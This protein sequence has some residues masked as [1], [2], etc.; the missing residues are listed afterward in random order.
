MKADESRIADVFVADCKKM[1]GR[2]LVCVVLFGSVARGTATKRSDM[3]FLV[4]AR[5]LPD[6][7]MERH[8][9]FHGLRVKYLLDRGVRPSVIALTPGDM[10]TDPVNPLF[11]G[12]LTGYNVLYERDGFFSKFLASLKPVV[13]KNRP[14]YSEGGAAGKRWKIA[15][16][17]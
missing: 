5:S 17:I 15:E 12:L 6:R 2:G 14:E 3:D 10:R 7:T 4:V 13:M 8:R 9:L 11:Y 16:I 1:F